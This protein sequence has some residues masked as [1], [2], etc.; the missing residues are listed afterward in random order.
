MI[1][2]ENLTKVFKS[3]TDSEVTALHNVSFTLEDGDIFGIIGMSGAGKS[4]LLRCLSMLERPTSGR[5]LQDGVDLAALR[6]RADAEIGAAERGLSP[7]AGGRKKSRR[8]RPGGRTAGT[9]GP[10]GQG[11]RLSGPAL[12]RAA[13][14]G[15]PRPGPGHPPRGPAQ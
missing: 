10:G 6:G 7:A 9:G 15:G 8:R 13:A 12:G 14:A 3:G 5:I 2:I 1:Q 4:T 11:G